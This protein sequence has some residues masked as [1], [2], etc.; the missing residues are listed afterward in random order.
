MALPKRA[1]VLSRRCSAVRAR[2][3]GLNARSIDE[4]KTAGLK[5]TRRNHRRRKDATD[6]QRRDQR[7]Q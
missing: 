5:E 3:V 2:R 7:Q 6:Y 1:T 4:M